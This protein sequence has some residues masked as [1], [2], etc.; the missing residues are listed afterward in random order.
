MAFSYLLGGEIREDHLFPCYFLYG[1]ET[2]LAHQ[3]VRQLKDALISPDAQGFNLERFDLADSRW[4]DII[5]LART[6]PFFFS[7]W[8]I[9]IVEVFEGRE[10]KLSSLEESIV[11]DYFRSPA[12]KTVLVVIFSGKIKR[13]HPFVKVFASLPTS[14]VFLKELKALKGAGLFSWIDRK[15]EGLGKSA[16]SEAKGR[17]AEIVGNDLQRVDN[18]LEKLVTFVSERRVIDLDDVNQICDWVKTSVFWELTDCLEK[19]DYEQT[20]I[21]LNR[22]FKEGFEPPFILGIMAN[23]FRDLLLAKLWLGENRDKKEIFAELKPR[24]DEKFR[25]LYTDK[26][27]EFFALVGGVTEEDLSWAIGDLQKIDLLTKTSDA[28]AQSLLER[29]VFDYCNRRNR[30]TG[31]SSFTWKERD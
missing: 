10:D 24:I 8:R 31:K 1:E 13:Y 17:L 29:F 2:Y 19:A 3:F 14:T 6:V 22:F 18:E 25:S 23:F 30:R 16:T 20:L 28:S 21:V 12:Q 9:V 7:P 27:K 11:R 26:F 4:A 15:L 5:D